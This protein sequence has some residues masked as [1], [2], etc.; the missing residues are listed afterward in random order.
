[1]NKVLVNL[2]VVNIL[3]YI[4][5][6]Q[7]ITLFTLNLHSSTCQLY[8]NKARIFYFLF[9]EMVRKNGSFEG[10]RVWWLQAQSLISRSYGFTHSLHHFITRKLTSEAIKIRWN[11]LKSLVIILF[12]LWWTFL[13]I[14]LNVS[15]GHHL[16]KQ[17][18]VWEASS[19]KT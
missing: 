11:N 6:Y 5:V 17:W 9:R 10:N 1:M 4:Y 14:M 2:I 18:G 13:R 12:P 19:R 16:Y 8:I 15:S 3:Q 7:M